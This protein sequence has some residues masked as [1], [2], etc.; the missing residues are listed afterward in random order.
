MSAPSRKKPK[1]TKRP[2][3]RD[4]VIVITNAARS[5]GRALLDMLARHGEHRQLIAVD[6]EPLRHD[7]PQGAYHRIYLSKKGASR[8]LAACVPHTHASVTIVHVAL[9]EIV[10]IGEKDTRNRLIAEAKNVLA[11]AKEL[12]A[13]KLVLIS[14][15][16]VYGAL[17]TNPAYLT[18]DMSTRGADQSPILDA[19]CTIEKLFAN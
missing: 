1:Q 15:T 17:A 9:P 16:D 7:L 13:H 10:D 14:S 18:E 8:K 6:G 3:K 19:L 12:H 5:L 2:H 11:A 4:E